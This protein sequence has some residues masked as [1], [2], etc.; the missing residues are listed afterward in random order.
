MI[1]AGPDRRG[2]GSGEHRWVE[3]RARIC[4]GLVQFT[5]YAHMD[6]YLEV[7]ECCDQEIRQDGGYDVLDLLDGLGF[8]A[9]AEWARG[10][11]EKEK[12]WSLKFIE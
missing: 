1:V 6:R 9:E 11:L 7:L 10:R 4:A 3:I 12:D 8:F 5:L 2:G